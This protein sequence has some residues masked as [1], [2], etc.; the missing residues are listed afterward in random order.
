MVSALHSSEFS[1]KVLFVS[2]NMY[3][4]P[5]G[6]FHYFVSQNGE[7]VKNSQKEAEAVNSFFPTKYLKFKYT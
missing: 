1:V 6:F 5:Q 4:V 2:L 7:T 3:E